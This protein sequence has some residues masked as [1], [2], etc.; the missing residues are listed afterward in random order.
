MS[1]ESAMEEWAK[2]INSQL[3]PHPDLGSGSFLTFVTIFAVAVAF[4]KGMEVLE[5]CVWFLKSKLLLREDASVVLV[6]P[7]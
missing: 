7:E 4:P 2:Q 5:K 3:S 1:A 6:S